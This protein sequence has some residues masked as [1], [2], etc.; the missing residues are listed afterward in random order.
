[1]IVIEYFFSLRY[2]LT[3][4]CFTVIEIYEIKLFELTI[5]WLNAR[6]VG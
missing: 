3:K 5:L 4:L 1:M 6:V 2:G